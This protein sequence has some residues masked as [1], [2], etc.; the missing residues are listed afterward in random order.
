MWLPGDVGGQRQG[1]VAN[2]GACSVLV[3]WP[4]RAEQS[5]RRRGQPTTF[6]HMDTGDGLGVVGDGQWCLRRSCEG[7]GDKQWP[8]AGSGGLRQWV[9]AGHG[10]LEQRKQKQSMGRGMVRIIGEGEGEGLA[11]AVAVA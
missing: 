5:S 7:S 9:Q 3:S 4:R 8:V 10:R 11:A 2:G 6:K 1:G